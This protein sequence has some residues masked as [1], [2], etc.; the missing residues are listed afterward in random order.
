MLKI[1]DKNNIG[2]EFVFLFKEII[3][4]INFVTT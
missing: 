3:K 1:S 2:I 4:Q